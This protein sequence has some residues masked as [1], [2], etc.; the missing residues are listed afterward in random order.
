MDGS[1]AACSTVFYEY[2]C[3]FANFLKGR[4]QAPIQESEAQETAYAALKRSESLRSKELHV[5]IAPGHNSLKDNIDQPFISLSR[6][7]VLENVER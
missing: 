1:K 3:L 5:C 4:T 6:R 2:D 7:R